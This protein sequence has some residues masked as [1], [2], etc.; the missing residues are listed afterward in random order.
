MDGIKPEVT[1]T[2]EISGWE[3]LT[4]VMSMLPHCSVV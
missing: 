3:N 2:I 4:T 1:Y